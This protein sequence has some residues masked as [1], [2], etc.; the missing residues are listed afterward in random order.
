MTKRVI[1]YCLLLLA[2]T[3]IAQGVQAKE[4]DGIEV[5]E[6]LP[7]EGDRPELFLNGAAKR[8]YLMF[9]DVYVGSLY[10]EEPSNDPNYLMSQDTTR[11][12]EF[13]ILRD[14]RGRRIAEA[15]YEGMRLNVPQEKAEAMS[16]GI[17]KILHMFDQ[18]LMP[19]D[20][21]VVEYIPGRGTRVILAG[22]DR[23]TI[24]GKDLFDAIL[25]IW[26][27]EYPVSSDFKAGILGTEDP[28]VMTSAP[29]FS[30]KLYR[31]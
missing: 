5:A 8:K 12:M 21:A 27:G 7:A 1:G 30:N 2:A 19:G 10:V 6:V 4:I 3:G 16:E 9:V 28:T 22:E 29:K 24:P 26:I 17:Q 13:N 23:G 31:D 25:S 15:F 11:R 20:K 18:R 14:V